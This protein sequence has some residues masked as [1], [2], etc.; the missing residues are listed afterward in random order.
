VIRY[1]YVYHVAFWK[2]LHCEEFELVVSLYLTLAADEIGYSFL[3]ALCDHSSLR[4]TCC[5]VVLGASIGCILPR[6]CRGGA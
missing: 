1:E 6:L 3:R 5:F 4:R 2:V